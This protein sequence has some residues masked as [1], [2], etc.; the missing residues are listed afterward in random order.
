MFL[1]KKQSV[2]VCIYIIETCSLKLAIKKSLQKKGENVLT[3]IPKRILNLSTLTSASVYGVVLDLF[4]RKMSSK[5]KK[6]KS[7]HFPR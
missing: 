7:E 3:Q 6:K 4:Q 1:K 2:C 5:K